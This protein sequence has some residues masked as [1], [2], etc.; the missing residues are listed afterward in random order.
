MGSIYN[1]FVSV[2]DQFYQQ[3]SSKATLDY[4]MLFSAPAQDC[5]ISYNV[6]EPHTVTEALRV[7]SHL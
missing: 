7:I 3:S 1:I 5:E 4:T 2:A 6:F